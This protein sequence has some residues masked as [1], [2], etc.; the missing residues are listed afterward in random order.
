MVVCSMDF[1]LCLHFCTDI[2]EKELFYATTDGTSYNDSCILI[3]TNIRN[4]L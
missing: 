1:K 4:N 2:F 3:A